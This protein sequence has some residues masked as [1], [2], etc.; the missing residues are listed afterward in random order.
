MNFKHR[1]SIKLDKNLTLKLSRK[2]R[3]FKL[4]ASFLRIID[5]KKLDFKVKRR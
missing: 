3:P 1:V 5:L 4:L 2:M